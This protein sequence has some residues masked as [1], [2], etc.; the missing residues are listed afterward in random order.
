MFSP[1]KSKKISFL[2]IGLCIGGHEFGDFLIDRVPADIPSIR[3]WSEYFGKAHIYGFDINDFSSFESEIKDFSFIRGDLT[4]KEDVVNLA[5]TT[6]HCERIQSPDIYDV[7]LDDGSHASFHQQQ[8]FSLLFPYLKDEG[9]YI[10]EDLHWQSPNYEDKL[11][12]VPKT[13]DVLK[14]L[15]CLN[16]VSEALPKDYLFHQEIMEFR[17]YIK[18]ID[19]YCDNKLAV[20]HKA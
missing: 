6:A 17:E 7:V 4:L 2:E 19:F 14:Q 12:A 5:K 16:D 9:I 11:P 15:E 1:L 10:I 13:I 20:I 8:A 3:I 18:S